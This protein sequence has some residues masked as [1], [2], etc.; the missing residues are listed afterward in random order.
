MQLKVCGLSDINQIN[1]LSNLNVDRLGF[2]FYAKS[3]RYVGN[4]LKA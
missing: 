2:I 3:P 1:M 4:K